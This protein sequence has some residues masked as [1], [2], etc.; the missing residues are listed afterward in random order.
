L[1][2]RSRAL[3]DCEP[4]V[5]APKTIAA[6]IT[7]ETSVFINPYRPFKDAEVSI[8]QRSCRV[9]IFVIRVYLGHLCELNCGGT[10]GRTNQPHPKNHKNLKDSAAQFVHCVYLYDEKI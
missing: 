7:N 3:T 8:W 5:A 2:C 4:S 1:S 10:A 9:Q 6:P